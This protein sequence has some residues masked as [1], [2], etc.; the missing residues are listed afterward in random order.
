MEKGL[1]S[2][3]SEAKRSSP[4]GREIK[5]GDAVTLKEKMSVEELAKVVGTR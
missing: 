2:K 3:S 4:N 1:P 5:E